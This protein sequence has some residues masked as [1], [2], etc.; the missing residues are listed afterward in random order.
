MSLTEFIRD[1]RVRVAALV[2]ACFLLGST[3][4]L[5]W[6]D[7][8]I[9]HAD[10]GQVDIFTMGVGYI[11]QALGLALFIFAAALLQ[12]HDRHKI[13]SWLV[14][15]SLVVYVILLDPATSSGA[16]EA[17]L[18]FGW[19]MNIL[20]GFSQGYY[21][22]CLAA[23]VSKN[24]RGTVFGCGYAASTLASW[25]ISS[26]GNGFLASGPTCLALC[27]VLAIVSATLVFATRDG[28]LSLDKQ[29]IS[30]DEGAASKN[31]ASKKGFSG[32]KL[33]IFACATVAMVSLVKNA[34]FSFPSED[35]SGIVNL[36][37]SRLFY[38][39]GLVMAGIMADRE[40]SYVLG[41]CALSLVAPF[42]MLALGNAGA[43]G[44]IMWAIGYLLFGFFT[45]FRVILLTDIAA[46]EGRLWL[47]P[48][49]LLFGRL[50][51]VLGTV[52]CLALAPV[53]LT[54]I[55]VTT[56]LFA[57]AA[58]M[59]FVLYHKLLLPIRQIATAYIDPLDEFC[60]D[61]ALSPREREII[62]LLVEGKT[63]AEIAAELYVT[64]STVKYHTR[65]IREKTG[66]ATRTEVANLYTQH[67]RNIDQVDE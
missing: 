62:P 58:W 24:R 21:L 38:G 31:G 30:P 28:L 11:A 26:L 52:C 44:V 36:E 7:N 16:L 65:N 43:S 34:G 48:A 54:L 27:A 39:I 53:P 13:L 29:T 8:V 9:R 10:P 49:G 15:T 56:V 18:G 35:L 14:I 22:Y 6:L 47:A 50:G 67:A 17:I 60:T 66:C 4:W 12:A 25:L 59:L 42:V 19:T 33:I 1:M 40:R 2:F 46:A 41:L 23:L 32:R 57:L 45:V 3:G 20:C 37:L 63:Y 51:D 5:S 64:E 55:P 61:Y